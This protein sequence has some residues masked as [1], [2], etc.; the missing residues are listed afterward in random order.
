[1][2]GLYATE[3]VEKSFEMLVDFCRAHS[4]GGAVSILYSKKLDQWMFIVRGGHE[5]PF[6]D[7]LKPSSPN[8]IF[9][10]Q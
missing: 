1:M 8:G 2:K 4:M 9:D 10:V 3:D 6:L 5:T 7:L